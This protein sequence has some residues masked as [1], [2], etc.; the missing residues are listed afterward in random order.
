MMPNQS[1]A[2]GTSCLFDYLAMFKNVWHTTTS[3]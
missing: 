1:I 3:R 2:C